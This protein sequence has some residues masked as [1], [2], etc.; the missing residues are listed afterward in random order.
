MEIF[1]EILTLKNEIK[2]ILK[3]AGELEKNVFIRTAWFFTNVLV[4]QSK[5]DPFTFARKTALK[6]F[7]ADIGANVIIRPGTRVKYPWKLKMGPNSSLGEDVWI[8]NIEKV[9]I[10]KRV[11]ISQ[12]AYLCTGNHNW[13]KKE[14]PLTAEPIVIEDNVWVGAK[15]TIGP[16]VTIGENAVIKLGAVVKN[17]VEKWNRDRRQ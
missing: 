9:E 5:G 14:R 2:R 4:L 8:D 16:G 15:S 17:S 6:V 12:G 7:G 10:G 1:E 3:P 11:V 13:R